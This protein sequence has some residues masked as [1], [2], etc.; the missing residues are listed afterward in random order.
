MC[1]RINCEFNLFEVRV[2]RVVLSLWESRRGSKKNAL[3]REWCEKKAMDSRLLVKRYW[4]LSTYW[5]SVQFPELKREIVLLLL[6]CEIW[7]VRK[8]VKAVLKCLLAWI[9]WI[10]ANST[11][12]IVDKL[13]ILNLYI[14]MF[15]NTRRYPL[16][17]AIRIVYFHRKCENVPP[18]YY[19][20]LYCKV[21]NEK[22]FHE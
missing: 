3:E 22:I 6:L 12:T 1:T 21:D 15:W 19:T 17:S 18:L 8:Y 5:V 13:R 2:R 4:W 11:G 20:K 10:I 9:K 16:T 7:F 14:Y